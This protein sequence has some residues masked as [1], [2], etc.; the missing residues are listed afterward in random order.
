VYSRPPSWAIY[1]NCTNVPEIKLHEREN[2]MSA[3]IKNILLFATLT[4]TVI[5]A[6]A[7]TEERSHA[8]EFFIWGFLGCCALIIVSQVVPLIRNVRKQSKIAAEE[9]KEVKQQ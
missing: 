4:T 5:P 1:G 3:L 8:P 7:A 6:L 2:V 9:T